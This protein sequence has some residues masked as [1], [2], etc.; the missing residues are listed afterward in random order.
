MF[1]CTCIKSDDASGADPSAKGVPPSTKSGFPSSSEVSSSSSSSLPP[2]PPST[3]AEVSSSSSSVPPT[4]PLALVSPPTAV[5]S[6][7]AAAAAPAAVYLGSK[8][9][10]T[11]GGKVIRYLKFG[12][13]PLVYSY[14]SLSLASSSSKEKDD[15]DLTEVHIDGSDAVVM[16]LERGG[17]KTTMTVRRLDNFDVFDDLYVFV[18]AIKP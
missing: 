6:A 3:T 16:T 13:Q 2:P 8:S 10:R 11:S 1:L 17:K 5:S 18:K 14:K 9:G 12:N 15:F 4:A 7:A